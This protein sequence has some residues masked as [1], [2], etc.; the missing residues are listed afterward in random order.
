MPR[1]ALLSLLLAACFPEP[2]PTS[3]TC[4]I[5]PA[6]PLA[7][8]ELRTLEVRPPP[9]ACRAQDDTLE[10]MAELGTGDVGFV[11][12]GDPAVLDVIA[13]F[14]GG[15]HVFASVQV[16]GL[17][18]DVPSDV[19][20]AFWVATGPGCVPP[21]TPSDDG[22]LPTTFGDLVPAGCDRIL[23]RTSFTTMT[24]GA[25][26]DDT[27]TAFGW[28]VPF[29]GVRPAAQ[30]ALLGVWVEDACGRTATSLRAVTLR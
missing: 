22:A 6:N 11:P 7:C 18:S 20:L 3:N 19:A 12:L 13:G 16:D 28:V 30:P 8:G 23:A 27:F 26:V 10:L 24:D 17:Y 2:E 15:Y 25:M 14:Q 29:G 9:S 5:D 1:P 21:T 4:V